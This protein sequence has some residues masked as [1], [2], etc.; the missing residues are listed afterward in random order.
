MLKLIFKNHRGEAVDLIS[1]EAVRLTD[2]DGVSSFC[3]IVTQ[4]IA[5]RD[6]SVPGAITRPERIITAN[7]RIRD[8]ADGE[9]AMHDMYRHFEAG[10]K[11]LMVMEGLHSDAQIEYLVKECTIPPNQK[12]PV[13]GMLTLLCPDPY[14]RAGGAE[15]KTVAGSISSFRFPFHFPVGSFKI[16]KNIDS[17]FATIYNPGEAETDM[18]IEF[19]A[20]ARVVNPALIDVKTGNAAR[21]R[22]TMEAGDVITINT[23]KGN[24]KISLLRNGITQNIFNYI[25]HP[26]TF[27]TLNSG[28]NT[29][30]YDAESG[31]KDLDIVVRFTAKF[32][33][34]YTGIR[35]GEAPATFEDFDRIIEEIAGVV[36]RGGLYG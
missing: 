15:S 17:V 27:F 14:F 3:D 30:K 4:S 21:L 26:F 18:Q 25:E 23:E 22:F 7:F 24:K 28:N 35:G 5:G 32:G 16:S 2:I 29:F 19:T 31:N 20:R 33:A 8:G 34:L 6:G 12:P 36:K 13:K 1:N 11:G 9:K 10:T